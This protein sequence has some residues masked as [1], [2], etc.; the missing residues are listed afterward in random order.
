[1]ELLAVRAIAFGVQ[2]SILSMIM[3]KGKAAYTS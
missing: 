3:L 1:M 2:R